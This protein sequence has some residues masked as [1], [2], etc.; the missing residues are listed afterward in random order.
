MS[1]RDFGFC[2]REN[3]TLNRREGVSLALLSRCDSPFSV[4]SVL[5]VAPRA[6]IR[7]R[8][9]FRDLLRFTLIIGIGQSVHRESCHL[10]FQR[11]FSHRRR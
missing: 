9:Q 11:A 8:D 7:S 6:P 4:S 10:Q 2:S 5:H 1:L 3:C